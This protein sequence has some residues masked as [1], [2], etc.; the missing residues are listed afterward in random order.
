MSAF[1]KELSN[2]SA[3]L[4]SVS[5][6]RVTTFLKVANDGQFYNSLSSGEKG[7]V[8]NIRGIL[9]DSDFQ[10]VIDTGRFTF[11]MIRPHLELGKK[12]GS[13]EEI[14]LEIG[15]KIRRHFDVVLELPWPVSGDAFTRFYG[16]VQEKLQR[17]PKNAPDGSQSNV[18]D[19]FQTMGTDASTSFLI[20]D[21][22]KK[23]KQTGYQ[24]WQLWR[25]FIGATN[26]LE[27][28]PGTLRGEYGSDY[29]NIVHGSDS[30]SAVKTDIA[31]ASGQLVDVQ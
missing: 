1:L 14:A 10:P 19:L 29:N 4:S 20:L 26:P 5:R 7:A 13:D 12:T 9:Q 27:A 31:W 25:T 22:Q 16:H 17:I 6:A 24:G 15:T 11:A 3:R 23:M 2:S 28:I 30:L 18:W 8:D 21:A